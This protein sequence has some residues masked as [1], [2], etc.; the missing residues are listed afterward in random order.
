MIHKI[1]YINTNGDEVE[2]GNDFHTLLRLY[3]QKKVSERVE[4]I[5]NIY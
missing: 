4:L 5:V 1:M 3:W 2:C